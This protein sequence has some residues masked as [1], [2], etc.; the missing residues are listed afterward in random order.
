VTDGV[1]PGRFDLYDFACHVDM[2]NTVDSIRRRKFR[3]YRYRVGERVRLLR[4]IGALNAGDEFVVTDVSINARKGPRP[5]RIKL[6]S[7]GDHTEFAVTGGL[8]LSMFH[9]IET[10]L[11]CVG[12]V[13]GGRNA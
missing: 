3:D 2:H 1:F 6:V 7:A 11:E 9:L 4:G 5:T 12:D 13:S 10:T 8:W